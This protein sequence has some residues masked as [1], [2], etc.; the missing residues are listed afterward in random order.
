MADQ[1]GV[2]AGRARHNEILF[3][4]CGEILL[5][6]I[7]SRQPPIVRAGAGVGLE[8]FDLLLNP[9]HVLRVTEELTLRNSLM[10]GRRMKIDIALDRLSRQQEEGAAQLSALISDRVGYDVA[11]HVGSERLWVPVD[12][13]PRPVSVPVEVTTTDGADLPRPVQ[14]EV[15]RALDAALWHVLRESLRAH[16]DF[17]RPGKAVNI[18]M[19]SNDAARWLVQDAL[20]SVTK[21]PPGAP[22]YRQRDEK[23]RRRLDG[24]DIATVVGDDLHDAVVR[25]A[26]DDAD[27]TPQQQALRVVR[28]ALWNDGP[29]LE[30]LRLV[31]RHYIVV[32][33]LERSV[34]D[35]TVQFD[36]P[37]NEALDNSVMTN[38]LA[39]FR[40]AFDPREHNYTMHVQIPLPD[41]VRQYSL[42]VT[43]ASVGGAPS[44][45]EVSLV[46]AIHYDDHPG[47]PAIEALRACA[48]ELQAAFQACEALPPTGG[49]SAD[50]VPADQLSDTQARS[51]V[52]V[53]RRALAAVGLLDHIVDQQQE[54]ANDLEERWKEASRWKVSESFEAMRAMTTEAGVRLG[55]ARKE[56]QPLA[57]DEDPPKVTLEGLRDAQVALE[58]AA[59][60][61]DRPL[62]GT[63]LVSNELP[64]Q[65][66]ARIRLGQ[67]TMLS[68]VGLRPRML[69]VWATISDEAVPYVFS[70]V[71]PPLSLAVFVLVTGWLLFSTAWWWLPLHTWD[72]ARVTIETGS[73]DA[74]AAVLLLSPAF[75][76]T[77]FRLPDRRSVAGRLRRPVHFFILV[78]IALLALVSMVVA[79]QVG[80]AYPPEEGGHPHLVLWV[81][82]VTLWLLALSTAR[83][84][85]A[86]VMRR[87]Y[88]WR[89][90]GLA[91]FFRSE[92]PPV[93]GA[94]SWAR[95]LLRW[96]GRPFRWLTRVILTFR[97]DR[98]EP[99]AE[100]D[101]TL[102]TRSLSTSPRSLQEMS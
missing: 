36:L 3:Q 91:A 85:I 26:G 46:G 56:V 35:H 67:S 2:V 66:V 7:P 8:L 77:Q 80:A 10:L 82:R 55:E 70:A 99:D 38:A 47:R 98:K 71:G 15:K 64:G 72:M 21:V 44:N 49:P 30:L 87:F 57:S 78:A 86:T 5:Q 51:V 89:P 58:E 50:D 95:R 92:S 79:T 41:N 19:R 24:T 29:F 34:R 16:P 54:A 69:E 83:A 40:R 59:R 33:G 39:R 81:F 13:V 60:A 75:A 53:A 17:E 31:H 90:K 4:L 11:G 27:P 61:T 93:V 96:L 9:D 68:G 65:E 62:L 63:R 12:T 1:A 84:C 23:V 76:L 97:Y 48:K 88:A 25:L 74:M 45:N 20:L 101:L 32:V 52:F 18:V 73:S 14:R 43:T 94:V 37:A 6:P 102:P 22:R 42:P 100:F 28:D